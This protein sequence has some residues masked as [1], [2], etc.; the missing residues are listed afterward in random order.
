MRLRDIKL[1]VQSDTSSTVILEFSLI[2]KLG[3][4]LAYHKASPCFFVSFGF[5]CNSVSIYA[6]CVKHCT[7]CWR[8]N[9]EQDRP[10][11]WT[12]GI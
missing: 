8:S 7:Q 9:S 3:F 11:H 4:F 6:L 5:G 2:Y 1:L 10:S 12:H